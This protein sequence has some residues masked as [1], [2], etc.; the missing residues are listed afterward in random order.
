MVEVGCKQKVR[1]SQVKLKR[2][3]CPR[4]WGQGERVKGK[5]RMSTN[6]GISSNSFLLSWLLDSL[7]PKSFHLIPSLLYPSGIHCFSLP[8]PKLSLLLLKMYIL[9]TQPKNFEEAL[10]YCISQYQ[11]SYSVLCVC[12]SSQSC[13]FQEVVL[14]DLLPLLNTELCVRSLVGKAR[15]LANCCSEKIFKL[16]PCKCLRL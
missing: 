10:F 6:K 13:D 3:L 16:V 4:G 12:G 2:V 9:P 5:C 7:C 1:G 15:S 11:S 14:M 8:N